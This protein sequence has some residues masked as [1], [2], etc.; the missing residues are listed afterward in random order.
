MRN[1]NI[2][3]KKYF[4]IS[5]YLYNLQQKINNIN[6]IHLYPTMLF[7]DFELFK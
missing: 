3:L 2:Y 1:L 6:I 5:F 7:G 4:I